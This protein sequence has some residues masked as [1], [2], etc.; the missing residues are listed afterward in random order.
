M[1]SKPWRGAGLMLAGWARKPSRVDDVTPEERNRRG[2]DA[3]AL[4]QE[5][6]HGIRGEAADRPN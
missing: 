5:L 1:P 3:D 6:K 4:F 2:D